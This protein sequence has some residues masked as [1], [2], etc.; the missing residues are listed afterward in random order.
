MSNS[1]VLNEMRKVQPGCTDRPLSG[2]LWWIT[3]IGAIAVT[4]IIWMVATIPFDM[5][6]AIV[7]QGDNI[8]AQQQNILD[9]ISRYWNLGPQILILSL[10]VYGFARTLKKERETGYQQ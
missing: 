5:M 9:T 6:F 1:I 8:G 2:L 10:I 3:I 7:E 4:T